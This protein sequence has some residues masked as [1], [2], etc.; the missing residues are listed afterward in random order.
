[1]VEKPMLEH[2]TLEFQNFCNI[3]KFFMAFEVLKLPTLNA[4]KSS[5]L[6]MASVDIGNLL[7]Q[8]ESVFYHR[9]LHSLF[10]LVYC[11]KKV[12]TEKLL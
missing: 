10:L 9:S 12:V 2:E 1:M 4:Y 8:T 3:L 6:K 5:F 11:A 7:N